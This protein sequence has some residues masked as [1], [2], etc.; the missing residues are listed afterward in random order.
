MAHFWNPRDVVPNSIM[1][2]YQWFFEEKGVLNDKGY[3]IIAYMQW[4]GTYGPAARNN[5]V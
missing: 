4:L 3:A 5:F 2:S 1:P